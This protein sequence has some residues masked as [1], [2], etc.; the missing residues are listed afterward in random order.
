MSTMII[1]N[2]LLCIDRGRSV[3]CDGDGIMRR[4]CVFTVEPRDTALKVPILTLPLHPHSYLPKS[5]DS[6]LAA[7]VPD[8]VTVLD[9]CLNFLGGAVL[10]GIFVLS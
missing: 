9:C 1:L 8:G 4:P 7:P 5:V 3:V 10:D 6:E 2:H